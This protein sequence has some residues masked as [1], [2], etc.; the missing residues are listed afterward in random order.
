M[1]NTIGCDLNFVCDPLGPLASVACAKLGNRVTSI[2]GALFVSAG[3]LFS[4]FATNVTYLYISMGLVV[5]E[6]LI[7]KVDTEIIM[8]KVTH[9]LDF[10]RSRVC[11]SLSGHICCNSDLFPKEAGN[12]IFYWT[13]WHGSDLCPRSIH[14]AA[15]GSVCLAG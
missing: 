1:I 2:V 3:F 5:G 10:S 4:I 14:S 11:S 6:Y 8:Q 13:F 15:F 12:G 9:K 7:L